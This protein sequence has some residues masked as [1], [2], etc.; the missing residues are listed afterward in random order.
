MIEPVTIG[1][2]TLY[3]GDCREILKEQ[4]FM[5]PSDIM[6][7]AKA[8]NDVYR[9]AYMAGQAA[10]ARIISRLEA[11]IENYLSGETGGNVTCLNEALALSDAS[12][13]VATPVMDRADQLEG[14]LRR[15]QK[16]G[17][18]PLW[19]IADDVA[20]A[21][22]STAQDPMFTGPMV[23]IPGEVH[24]P[25]G[26]VDAIAKAMNDAL[27]AT[28]C[29]NMAHKRYNMIGCTECSTAQRTGHDHE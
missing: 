26:T 29:Q 1:N 28:R 16:D 25:Q 24:S 12:K 6:A 2:S 21:L 27:D 5:D 4:G 18:D 13:L 7:L 3:L 9:Q 11:A 23:D 19:R 14:L 17:Y 8:N 22:G 15:I 10:S 20:E